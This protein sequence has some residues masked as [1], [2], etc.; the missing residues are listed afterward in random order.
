[1]NCHSPQEVL[2]RAVALACVLLL[3]SVVPMAGLAST[4]TQPVV[5]TPEASAP[6]VKLF[7]VPGLE[8][9]LVATGATTAAEDAV[10]RGLL[11]QYQRPSPA[12]HG[13]RDLAPFERFLQDHP[14]SAWRMAVL[15][16]LGLIHYRDGYF[17]RAIDAWTQA[18]AAGRTATEP[19]ARAL[20][21]RAIGE[22]LRMHA[23]LGHADQLT[24]LLADLGDRSLSGPASEALA[25]AREGLWSMQNNP[26]IAYL[27]GPMALKNLLVA[28][29]ASAAQVRFLDD[30]R[31]GP[32]GVSLAEVAQLA[33]QAKLPYQLVHREAG[34]N[35]P[36]PA[37]VHWKLSHF[38]AIVAEENGHFQLKDPTFGR[39]LWVTRAALEAESSGYFLIPA[40]SKPDGFQA[41]SLAEAGKVRGM[42]NTGNN[43][44]EA[45]TPDDQTAQPEDCDS[46]GMC[47]YS[48]TEMVVSLR[49]KD[50]PVGYR[51]PKGPPVF[52]TLTYNQREATQPA[53]FGYFNVGSRWSMNWL[54]FIVDDPAIPGASVSRAVAGGG[55]TVYAGY[56]SSTGAFT[57]ER[58]KGAVLVR[59]QDAPITYERRLPDGSVE[60]Y[61]QGDGAATYP[62]RIF[63]TRRIDPAGNAVDLTYDAQQRLLAITDATGRITTLEYGRPDWPLVVTRVTDPFGRSAQ[64]TYDASGHL[65]AITDVLGL[66]SSFVYNSASQIT[67]LATPYGTTQFRFGGS[68]NSRYLEATD[69]LGHVERLEY[70]HNPPGVASSDPASLVPSGVLGLRNAYLNYRNTIYWDKN[71][72]QLGAGT[73]TKGRIK[74]WTHLTSTL[75][76]DLVESIKN[77][78]E[79]RIWYS[80]P[81]QPNTINV[82]TLD[83]P[84]RAGRVLDDGTTQLTQYT[85]NAAGNVTS[86]T[87]PV[88]RVTFFDYAANQ[89]DVIAVRQQTANGS[90]TLASFT[91]NAQH[92]PLTVKDAAGNTTT[93][94]YNAAGQVLTETE[95]LNQTTTYTYDSLGYLLRIQNPNGTTRE[96]YT[97]DAQ[98]RIA[99]RTDS[100]GHTLAYAYDAFD[101]VIS[102][103]WPDGTAHTYVYDKLDLV[104]ETDREGRTTRYEHDANRNRTTLIDPEARRTTYGYDPDGRLIRL[105]DPNGNLTTWERD[106]QGRVTAKVFADGSRETYA[107]EARTS[108]LKSRTDALGQIA[109]RTYAK[110][111][112][113]TAL[114]YTNAVNQTPGVSFAY[115]TYFPRLTSMTDGNGVTA[116]S[117]GAVGNNGA[118]QLTAE[119][120]PFAND[121]L[122][123]DYDALGR[124]TTRTI[125]TTPD[126]Y[127]YDSLGRLTDHTTPLGE[128]ALSYLGQ[129]GQVVQRALISDVIAACPGSVRSAQAVAENNCIGQGYAYGILRRTGAPLVTTWQYGDNLHDRHLA[130]INHSAG[131]NDNS[132]RNYAYT[133][134]PENRILGLTES[135][136][137]TATETWGYGY[138]LADRLTSALAIPSGAYTYGLDAGDNLLTIQT[139]ASSTTS[140]YDNLNQIDLRNAQ[141]FVYDAAGNLLNDGQRT[142]TWD[143]E[144]RLIGIGYLATPAVSTILRYDGLGRRTAVIEN[145]N[146]S[147]AETRYLWCGERI[148]QARDASDAIIRRYYDEGELQVSSTGNT[149]LYY[150]QDHLGSVRDLVNAGGSG[151]ATYDYDPYGQPT[152]SIVYGS[153]R[154]DYRYA[155]LFYHQPSGLYLTHYRV[156]DPVTARWLSRDPIGE[157]GG[158]N[159]YG[160]VGGNPISHV[161]PTGED[162]GL[163][164]FLAAWAIAYV[165]HAGDAISQENGNVSEKVRR[166]DQRC[167]L[168]PVLGAIGDR[169]FPEKCMRHDACFEENKCNASSWISSALGGTK[170]CNQCN[171][172]FF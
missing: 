155:G 8:E 141:P 105:T 91:Y 47:R 158:I 136:A 144:Q 66:T 143:A 1:M 125:Y 31:S 10:L 63:L 157:M 147:S 104:A 39:D 145:N 76:S 41:V 166:Q 168:G 88:G 27:C 121:P 13:A 37:I 139:P 84:N 65:T 77:P 53:N 51:P 6:L 57:P 138:D 119:D 167:T 32:Q 153:A 14:Q 103:T 133:T 134:S 19:R 120:G 2:R 11:D 12:P 151:L 36:V 22:L 60:V 118:L 95:P 21:D 40:A 58:K 28:R 61:A 90:V 164:V 128:F 123:Y 106:I 112:R 62:R 131:P 110:D 16:N 29:G 82:G 44:P 116:Y 5:A 83:K 93:Y 114:G 102:E 33:K 156:Y 98:G 150:A 101:R 152:R 148:C 162:G 169:C 9:P 126:T 54:S 52:L 170:S 165:S 132:A 87:D 161:D 160:Y 20:A 117:Y 18:W 113:L 26:G 80:Y 68:G 3:A 149:P 97:Y 56:N 111:D 81:G 46:H 15:T 79:S 142:Y 100:E 109:T 49:L 122:A 55:G 135:V 34:G 115:D 74:H 129:T 25:G 48:F 50:T 92:R 94:T 137:G 67:N 17:S 127:A 43:M 107:Y 64:L 172:D 4:D 69:P 72:Y 108:R 73:Y 171:G 7:S 23:R 24:A 42:G 45:T 159:L 86:T 35:I 59:I 130:A 146:G 38:A 78:L 85:Y 96:A 89:I 124:V 163:T 154:A 71:A 30:Y 70:R 75:T 99:T 140:T